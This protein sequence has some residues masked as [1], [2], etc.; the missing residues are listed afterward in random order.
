MTW[1][2]SLDELQA[3]L[4]DAVVQCAAVPEDRGLDPE[5]TH[6][7]SNLDGIQL[8]AAHVEIVRINDHSHGAAAPTRGNRIKASFRRFRKSRDAIT[9]MP[10]RP[11]TRQTTNGRLIDRATA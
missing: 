1:L 11:A 4:G 3:E 9:I 10:N 8:T 7:C 5:V 2:G 6:S